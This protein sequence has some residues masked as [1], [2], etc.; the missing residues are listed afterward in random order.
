M[1]DEA[2]DRD[3][4]IVL[5]TLAPDTVPVSLRDAAADAEAAAATG[6]IRFRRL[7]RRPDGWLEPV[8]SG[9]VGLVGLSLIAVLVVVLVIAAGG[10]PN[11][12]GPGAAGQPAIRWDTGFVTLEAGSVLVELGGRQFTGPA[13]PRSVRSDPG[14]SDYRTLEVEWNDNGVEMRINIYFAAD[15]NDWWSTEIRTYDGGSPGDWIT[16]RGEFFRT[17][18]GSSWTGDLDLAGGQGRT[19]GAL[20]IDDLRLTAFAPGTV[21]S[22]EG[23]TAIGPT[24]PPGNGPVAVPIDQPFADTGIRQGMSAAAAHAVLNERGICH[25]FRL[26]FT[27][28]NYAQ[29]WCIPPP[30]DVESA[31]YGSE[32][33]LIIFVEDRVRTLEPNAPQSVGC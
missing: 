30:G 26:M 6:G 33:Q 2:F 17:D 28:S 22:F 23:C 10:Q 15:A 24:E 5:K 31:H 21:H 25:E 20:H 32:G 4:R 14:S 27:Q 18:I 7:F 9:A 11:R 13:R 3:L 29:R 19:S 1:S 8:M 12:T 16:Y